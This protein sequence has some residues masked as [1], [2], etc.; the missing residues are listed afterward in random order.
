[1]TSAVEHQAVLN[2]CRHI[3]KAGGAVTFLPV[4]AAGRVDP[5]ALACSLRD[6]TVLISVMAAN[7]ETGTLQPLRELRTAIGERQILLHTDA[8]SAVGKIPFD[9]KA[10]GI[11]LLTFS[12]HKLHGPAGV[13][14]LY[15]RKGL[16]LDPLWFG[17]HQEKGLRP[18]TENVIAIAGFGK[19][20]EIALPVAEE[21]ARLTRLRDA[22]EVGLAQKVSG[23]QIHAVRAPRVCNTSCVQFDGVDAEMLMLHLDMS[24]IAVST[25]AACAS[26]DREPSHVLLAMGVSPEAARSTLRFSFGRTNT[27]EELPAVI[28]AL[29]EL[30]PMLRG[31][32]S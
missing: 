19:A 7:N 10:S 22:F 6:D 28:Q 20:C 2:P 25:Q 11:D 5:A 14:A 13:G 21:A 9:V 8:V 24:G 12:A 26:G 16:N 1:V 15:V 17:G 23:V 3:G 31:G 29:E 4:D 32:L 30:V 18:G 27:P